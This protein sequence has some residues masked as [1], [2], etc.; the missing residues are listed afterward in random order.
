MRATLYSVAFSSVLCF[1]M[2]AGPACADMKDLLSTADTTEFTS[3]GMRSGT[4]DIFSQGVM[5][6]SGSW[7]G[8]IYSQGMMMSTGDIYSQGMEITILGRTTDSQG[9]DAIADLGG[10]T[11]SPGTGGV[12][13]L[14]AT[15]NSPG[16]GGVTNL[17]ATTNS[18]GTGSV[19]NVGGTANSPPPSQGCVGTAPNCTDNVT[20]MPTSLG[21]PNSGS[22]DPLFSGSAAYFTL[23]S[24][25]AMT[26]VSADPIPEP[27]GLALLAPAL[28]WFGLVRTRR[29]QI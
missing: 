6:K 20:N 27:A 11:N 10:T 28:L 1:A 8:E 16:T 17:G 12:T 18:P 7:T 25:G 5:A 14:G 3:Q 19:T 24:S 2:L 9:T 23:E 4:G 15:T 22:G 26:I 21:A 29:N 13:N